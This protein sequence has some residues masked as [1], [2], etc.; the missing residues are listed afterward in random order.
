MSVQ[1]NDPSTG[2][3][4]LRESRLSWWALWPLVAL[5]LLG[6]VLAAWGLLR[7]DHVGNSAAIFGALTF[8]WFV[9]RAWA[10]RGAMSVKLTTRYLVLQ[11]GIV[12][13]HTSTVMLNR[14]ESLD[15]DQ[16]LWQRMTGYGTLT[17]RG[18]GS[19]DLRLKGISDPV[20][21]QAEA[22]KAINAA[23]GAPL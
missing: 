18:T 1:T 17:I 8:V 14:V 15:V 23:S 22:R 11:T 16:S 2:E 5:G 19:E 12:S 21:F 13:R 6:L 20:G 3:T 9:G 7:Q 10:R 4:I